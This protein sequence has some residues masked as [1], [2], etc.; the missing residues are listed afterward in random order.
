MMQMTAIQN[1]RFR[2]DL[3]ERPVALIPMMAI[4]MTN[5]AEMKRTEKIQEIRADIHVLFGIA[6]SLRSNTNA[7]IVR[8]ETNDTR[9]K[10]V[11]IEIMV[12]D[13][14]PRKNPLFIGGSLPNKN[15]AIAS[16][17]P[18]KTCPFA[19]E[20]KPGSVEIKYILSTEA[21]NMIVPKNRN[22]EDRVRKATDR[23]F[24][25]LIDM[26][27]TFSIISDERSIVH[28]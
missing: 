15:V 13:M 7:F 14:T 25:A 27:L 2:L 21:N 20:A 22:K 6:T 26:L 8:D 9:Y 3:I 23:T 28:R 17:V 19:M 18:V 1:T 10:R 4:S 11:S 16:V 12:T 24:L 5:S